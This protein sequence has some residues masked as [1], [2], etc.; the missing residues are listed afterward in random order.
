MLTLVLHQ[1][2]S[3]AAPRLHGGAFSTAAPALLSTAR[4]GGERFFPAQPA[5]KRA[6]SQAAVKCGCKQKLRQKP[7]NR[8]RAGTTEDPGLAPELT[9][10]GRARDLTPRTHLKSKHRSCEE[11]KRI[12]SEAARE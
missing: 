9:R 2:K 11:E 12:R 5:G 6:A 3:P 8:N 4:P 10:A 1:R 7:A